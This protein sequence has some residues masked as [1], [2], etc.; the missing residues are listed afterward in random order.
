[1]TLT[2]GILKAT[3]LPRVLSSLGSIRMEPWQCFAELV[4]NATDGF[5]SVGEDP[6][7][8]GKV[9]QVDIRISVQGARA[10]HEVVVSD[11][12]PGMTRDALEK[13]ITAGYSSRAELT[14]PF[15]GEF[16]V[17][18]NI[19]MARLGAKT[20]IMTKRLGDKTPIVADI[21]I[22]K[23]QES[24]RFD[25]P[26]YEIDSTHPMWRHKEK[27]D[28]FTVVRISS[29]RENMSSGLSHPDSIPNIRKKLGEVYSPILVQG[30]PVMARIKLNC[31]PVP[32]TRHNIWGM[33][34]APKPTL[35][36]VDE[37]TLH[38]RIYGWVGIQRYA[39]E[40]DYGIDLIR[41]GRKIEPRSRALFYCRYNGGD[42][43]EY[44]IDDPRHRGRIVGEIHMDDCPLSITKDRFE[45]NHPLWGEM[46]RIFRGGADNPL[47]PLIA[48]SRGKNNESP[49]AA[50]YH[51]FRRNAPSSKK[52]KD[53]GAWKELLAFPG[54]GADVLD[55]A[56]PP[57][58]D[59]E[60]NEKLHSKIREHVEK[61]KTKSKAQPYAFL[62][63]L[64]SKNAFVDQALKEMRRLRPGNTPLALCL[65]LRAV[66]EVSLRKGLEKNAPI[67]WKKM[68]DRRGR[69]P[70]LAA[71]VEHLK[72]IPKKEHIFGGNSSLNRAT[73]AFVKGPAPRLAGLADN[74]AHGHIKPSKD[75]SDALMDEAA[76]ILQEIIN[77]ED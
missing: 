62:E 76:V 26:W 8:A 28:H 74:V 37:E 10:L 59:K 6:Q 40:S 41:C 54:G 49:L 67:I 51:N 16:G 73:H 64:T 65:C 47:R 33:H 27:M 25:F 7:Y 46:I 31:S 5:V 68:V 53:E 21:D 43:L 39:H 48:K 60:W 71:M 4:D 36:E 30:N 57:S 32:G 34:D 13:A 9:W 14:S 72:N 52:S 58:T 38:G 20:E 19:A 45:R 17:G 42:E 44:P 75:M 56:P 55:D 18:L 70:G 23:A 15:I 24:G 35:F 29:L 22:N 3:P 63:G 66:I 50:L 61:E 11:N 69:E 2:N 77:A 1:M 12:G